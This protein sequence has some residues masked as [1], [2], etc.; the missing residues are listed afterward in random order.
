MSK[1]DQH[2]GNGVLTMMPNH[3]EHKAP[4]KAAA[5]LLARNVLIKNTLKNCEGWLSNIFDLRPYRRVVLPKGAVKSLKC[6][7]YIFFRPRL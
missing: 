6:N 4:I 5:A 1:V 2:I 7:S 3:L